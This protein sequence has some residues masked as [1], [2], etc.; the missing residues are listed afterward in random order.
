MLFS[1]A[2]AQMKAYEPVPAPEWMDQGGTADPPALTA[3]L[4]ARIPQPQPQSQPQEPVDVEVVEGEI[5][6]EENTND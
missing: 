4:T 2:I 3:W 5:I 6:E 1:P